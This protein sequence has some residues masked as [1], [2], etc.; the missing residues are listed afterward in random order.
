MLVYLQVSK[1]RIRNARIELYAALEYLEQVLDRDLD[2]HERRLLA[3]HLEAASAQCDT[4]ELARLASLLLDFVQGEWIFEVPPSHNRLDNLRSTFHSWQSRLY[5][6]PAARPGLA[7]GLGILGFSS[8][9]ASVWL[10]IGNIRMTGFEVGFLTRLN[11]STAYSYWIF[12]LAFS[13]GI[14]G[15]GLL[16]GAAWVWP[17]LSVSPSINS[18]YSRGLHWS[19]ASLVLQLT[20]LDLLLFYYLQFS[21]A[22]LVIIQLIL[23]LAVI[24]NDR[25]A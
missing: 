22:V 14:T 1:P 4:P 13:F 17:D 7:A 23:L 3:L 6:K 10:A 19:F 20:V 25:A 8:I 18:R 24:H 15:L 12:T 21:T 11:T 2:P 5:A 9:S 16:F